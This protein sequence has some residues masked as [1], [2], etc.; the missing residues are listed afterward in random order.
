M[1][2]FEQSGKIR[3]ESVHIIPHLSLFLFLTQ[4][5]DYMKQVHFCEEK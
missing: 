5:V 4:K 3:T 1:E 2:T